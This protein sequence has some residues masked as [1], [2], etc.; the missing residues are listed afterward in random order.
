MVTKSICAKVHNKFN[1]SIGEV[2]SQDIY[3]TIV[4]GIS[5]VTTDHNH[6]HSIAEK[7]LSFIEGSTEG[8]IIIID[9][10]IY[11]YND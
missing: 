5:Y 4:I 10:E 7:V 2:E 8:E 6:A 1:V 3:Q 9:R 11:G